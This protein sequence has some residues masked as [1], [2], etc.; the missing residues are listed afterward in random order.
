MAIQR[1]GDSCCVPHL[2][3]NHYKTVNEMS[4]KTPTPPHSEDSLAFLMHTAEFG[5]IEKVVIN[6][7]TYISRNKRGKNSLVLAHAK[8]EFLSTLPDEIE[9]IDLKTSFSDRLSGYAALLLSITQYL[10]SHKPDQVVANLRSYNTIAVLA[11]FLSGFSG[12]LILVEHISISETLGKTWLL[13]IL[14]RFLYPFS[15]QVVA[16]SKHMKCQ[17]EEKIGLPSRH[18]QVIYNPVIDHT[19]MEKARIGVDHPWFTL[20]EP[21]VILAVGRLE[22][23][24]NFSMLIKAFAKL[25]TYQHCRL[26]ILGDG[27]QY[28]QLRQ[29]IQDLNLEEDAALLGFTPNPYA[30]MAKAALLAL[31]SRSEGLPTVLVEA[32]ALGLPIVATDCETGPAEILDGGRY[33]WLVSVGD[34][35]GMAQAMLACLEG[36]QKPI[37]PPWL[38]QFTVRSAAEKYW[39]LLDSLQK[40]A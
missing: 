14:M 12:N 35:E 34:V 9:I 37:D 27:S 32:M 10:R 30:Y 20:G 18:I 28:R 11:K 23:H 38:E 16:V 39:T 3:E 31:S 5:G 36:K 33:G 4:T 29:L 19:L 15:D 25:R 8:G 7:I 17:L 13:P 24:K 21:P 2:N 1:F 6:L 22:S 40:K 26:V